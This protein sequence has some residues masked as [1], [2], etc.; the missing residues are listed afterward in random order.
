[1]KKR[2]MFPEKSMGACFDDG[3]F[4]MVDRYKKDL[5]FRFIASKEV[6]EAIR[7]AGAGGNFQ[8]L[9]P[10][11]LNG[12]LESGDLGFSFTLPVGESLTLAE[13]ILSVTNKTNRMFLEGVVKKQ[14]GTQQ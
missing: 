4:I 5:M 11:T 3:S 1:M 9:K 10:V 8:Q 12:S 2:R 14:P 7:K 6:C 13:L